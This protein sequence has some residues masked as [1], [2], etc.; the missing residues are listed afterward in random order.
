MARAELYVLMDGKVMGVLDQDAPGRVSFLY[1]E[2]WLARDL[3]TPLSLSM[4]ILPTRY[5]YPPVENWLWGLLPDNEETLRRWAQQFQV[6][7]RNVFALLSHLGEDVAGAVQIVRPE[8]REAAV[9]EGRIKWLSGKEFDA[10]IADLHA[11]IGLARRA[12]DPGRFSLAGVQAKTAFL[13]KGGRWGV[14]S[15]NIATNRIVKLA[16]NTFDGL[17]ENEHF[18][19][20]L[21]SAVGLNAAATEVLHRGGVT[22][23]VI[24]RYDRIEQGKQLLRL[25]Q[26]DMCQARGVHPIYRYQNEGGPGVFDIFDVLRA[27]S[28]SRQD[29]ETFLRAQV[30]N[31][32]VGGTDAHAKNFSVLLGERGKVR[33]APLYD[34]ASMLPYENPKKLR[35]AMRIGRSYEF[36]NTLPRHWRDLGRRLRDVPAPVDILEEY[37][38][39]LPEIAAAVAGDCQ[40]EG[41]EHPVLG[42]LVDAVGKMCRKTLGQIRLFRKE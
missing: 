22:A 13:Y 39:V 40:A 42:R 10:R 25:H 14:P 29:R 15:G 35:L 17:I 34:I 33:L 11:D 9:A 1:S 30:F 37:V 3:P 28:E 27:S 23:I 4:P 8:R 36:S 2:D 31:F 24:E 32:L 12:D 18:C 26:E 7:P 19:L 20:R 41:L 16:G 6:S 21:A 38:R 5:A